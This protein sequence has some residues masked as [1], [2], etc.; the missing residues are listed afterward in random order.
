MPFGRYAAG[1]IGAI[2]DDPTASCRMAGALL[3]RLKI[4]IAEHIFTDALAI[5]GAEQ[6]GADRCAVPPSEYV[7]QYVHAVRLAPQTGGPQ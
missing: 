4:Y 5:A 7:R 1:I 3:L 2:V 6:G